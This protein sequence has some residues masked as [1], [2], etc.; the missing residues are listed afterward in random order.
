MG[1][2]I[3]VWTEAVIAKKQK[4]G[5]GSGEGTAYKPWLGAH[6]VA[7]IGTLHR[8]FS[9]AFGRSIHMLSDVEWRTFLLLEHSKKFTQVY[10]CYPLERDV[11]LQIAEALR[12]RHPHYPGTHIPTVM[13]VDFLGVDERADDMR[14]VAFDCK[15]SEEA[16]NENS[17]AKL[18]IT[19]EY[20]AGRGVP[21][22]L[23]FHSEL[24]ME[25]V[26]NVEWMRSTSLKEGEIERYPGFFQDKATQMARELSAGTHAMPLNKFCSSFEFRHQMAPGEGLR[27]AGMLMWEHILKGDICNPDLKS[28]PL[29]SFVCT[30][31]ANLPRIA[32]L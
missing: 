4:R 28:A 21:H 12:I 22:H 6:D 20:F 3:Q 23:V 11:T 8:S 19:R 25:K 32:S 10:E 18:Q 5:D 1:K 15:R 24:P 27:V 2:G 16:E 30:P 17:I 29:N 13:T 31:D 26:K 14:I 7:S 9:Q